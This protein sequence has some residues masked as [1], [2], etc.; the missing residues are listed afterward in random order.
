M[1]IQTSILALDYAVSV[2]KGRFPEGEQVIASH[3]SDACMYA[4]EV[5][6]SRFK[7]AESVIA[8]DPESANLYV[9]YFP[10]SRDDLI[11]LKHG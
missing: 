1:I 7:Q 2:V 10:E 5:L 8:Q 3:P 4:I 9:K 6:K 11:R